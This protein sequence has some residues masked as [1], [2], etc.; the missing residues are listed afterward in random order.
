LRPAIEPIFDT[1]CH[2]LPGLDDGPPTLGA[3][4]AL[5]GQLRQA[6]VVRALCTPHYSRQYP[7]R[8]DEAAARLEDLRAALAE[9]RIE[10]TLDLAAEL[11]PGLVV[12][13]NDEELFVRTI[14]GRFLLV[15]VQPDTTATFLETAVQ[16]VFELGLVPV[17][18]HPER[19]RSL[20]RHLEELESIR[21]AGA[22]VQIVAPSLLGDAGRDAAATAWGL[23]ERG[24][25]DVLASDS[26]GWWRSP[27]FLYEAAGAVDERFGPDIR[28]ALTQKNPA[29]LLDGLDPRSPEP[30]A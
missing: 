9:A 26:H 22:V 12:S 7:T 13:A 14:A 18:A 20:S 30:G 28:R 15:E 4:I 11:S 17:L 21:N 25:A 8:H 10:L 16:R 3:A 6:G 2:V 27:A 19:G 1:H 24:L 5:A 23:L 29:M